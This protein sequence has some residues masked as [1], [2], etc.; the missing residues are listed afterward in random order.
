MLYSVNYL[1]YQ[2]IENDFKNIL[3]RE[4]VEPFFCEFFSSQ[5]IHDIVTQKLVLSFRLAS[6]VR[7]V[8]ASVSEDQ[9]LVEG[10]VTTKTN[11]ES[12]G[13]RIFCQ[14]IAMLI[15]FSHGP[16]T[17]GLVNTFRK[18]MP[19]D[20]VVVEAAR[21]ANGTTPDGAAPSSTLTATGK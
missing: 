11:L 4:M 10:I 12:L 19:S 20:Q 18:V 6:P 13:Y 2:N 17:E 7:I 16:K 9:F 1:N 5:T 15:G 3:T 21:Q 14:P 8:S